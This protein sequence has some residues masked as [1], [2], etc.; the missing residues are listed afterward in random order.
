MI[1]YKKIW[2]LSVLVAL[3]LWPAAAQGQSS[4]LRNANN[5]AGELD[6]QG[7]YREAL[8]FAEEA[9]SLGEQEFGLDHPALPQL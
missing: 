3:V 6:T 5:R 9:L 2:L 1:T 4:E 8:P 7:R